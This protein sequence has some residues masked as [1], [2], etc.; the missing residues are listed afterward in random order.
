[1]I[2]T[3]YMWLVL[4]FFT[5]TLGPVL[6]L[7]LPFDRKGRGYFFMVRAWARAI[8]WASRNPVSIEG[9]SKVDPGRPAIYMTNHQS[10]FDVICLSALLPVPVRFVAKRILVYLPVFGQLLWAT[11]HIIIDREDRRQSFSSLD[12]AA[13]KIQEGTSVLVFPEGTRSPDHRLGLFKKGGFVLGIKAQVPIV[14]I[15]IAGTRPMMP[16]G[17]FRF[18]RTSV[19]MVVGEPVA[20]AGVEIQAKENLM[21]KVRREISSRFPLDSIEAKV[22]RTEGEPSPPEA[23]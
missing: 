12:R 21:E 6:A 11:G 1:M 5:F 4:F 16:K 7:I 19:R 13:R 18:A 9:L 10:Y 20:T 17:S 14:P 2:Y 23:A 22:N 8:I 15:S 3:L